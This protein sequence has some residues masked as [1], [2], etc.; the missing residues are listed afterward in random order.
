MS[1]GLTRRVRTDIDNKTH[2]WELD[3][4]KRSRT[5]DMAL[6]T[7]VS[8]H[9]N[10]SLLYTLL[11][12]E[13]LEAIFLLRLFYST[14]YIAEYYKL[15]WID[16][17]VMTVLY[18][19]FSLEYCTVSAVSYIRFNNQ[20]VLSSVQETRQR[21]EQYVERQHVGSVIW[22]LVESSCRCFHL[23]TLCADKWTFCTCV[24]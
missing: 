21:C 4:K 7:A 18:D 14:I 2:G 10:W 11:C 3:L 8:G 5:I 15:S 24:H 12:L 23:K 17:P 1:A 16:L 9:S 13:F 19:Y 22:L 6:D 20:R